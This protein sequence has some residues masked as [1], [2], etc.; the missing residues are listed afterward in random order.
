MGGGSINTIETQNIFVSNGGYIFNIEIDNSSAKSEK[1]LLFDHLD[2]PDGNA[3]VCLSSIYLYNLIDA[4]Y[5]KKTY[6]WVYH[7]NESY[8]WYNIDNSTIFEY[9]NKNKPILIDNFIVWSTEGSKQ[10][11]T[12]KPVPFLMRYS[13]KMDDPYTTKK[14]VL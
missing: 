12:T 3:R 7:I 9:N 10:Y 6:N 2:M 1:I 14:Y 13:L 8:R 5:V 4:E 11:I